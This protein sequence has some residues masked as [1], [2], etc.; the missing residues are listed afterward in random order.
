MKKLA[1]L[2]LGVLVIGGL[3]YGTGEVVYKQ[4]NVEA[5]RSVFTGFT[6][7]SLIQKGDS[8]W[9][10]IETSNGRPGYNLKIWL[11]DPY[12]REESLR[13]HIW[14]NTIQGNENSAD[15]VK[16]YLAVSDF[17]YD[18][19]ADTFYF[20][21]MFYSFDLMTWTNTAGAD[22]NDSLM[23]PHYSYTQL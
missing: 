6:L 11:T 3:I 23:C 14:I 10:R 17:G 15:S 4:G 16:K 21:G 19:K 5:I 20:Y 22:A 8:T 12:T 1:F 7:D 9:R 2:L 13:T 18:N